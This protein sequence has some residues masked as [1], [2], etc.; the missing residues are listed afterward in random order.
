MVPCVPRVPGRFLLLRPRLL[1]TYSGTHTD[2][3]RG[4]RSSSGRRGVVPIL[5]STPPLSGTSGA[6]RYDNRYS[7]TNRKDS[8]TRGERFPLPLSWID[9]PK[10]S[11]IHFTTGL[12]ATVPLRK[13]KGPHFILEGRLRVGFTPRTDSRVDEWRNWVP[14]HSVTSPRSLTPPVTSLPRHPCT[15]VKVPHSPNGEDLLVSPRDVPTLYVSELQ[16]TDGL[17]TLPTPRYSRKQID[18]D[19]TIPSLTLSGTP[20]G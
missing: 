20:S 9:R 8:E 12:R 18:K 19:S 3:L 4:H 14:T 6:E 13:L 17:P 5:V 11:D 15:P 10:Q 1:S 7:S 16:T 2:T